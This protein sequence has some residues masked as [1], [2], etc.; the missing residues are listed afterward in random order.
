MINRLEFLDLQNNKIDHL[1]SDVF[2]GLANVKYI[3]LFGN[4]LHYLHP[5]TF[6]G[7]I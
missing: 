5:D 1:E 4:K 6:F 2:R 7:L 3:N